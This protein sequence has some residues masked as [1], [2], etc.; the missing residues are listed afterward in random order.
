MAIVLDG[1]SGVSTPQLTA[2]GISTP[3]LTADGI[4]TPQL[5]AGNIV[6]QVCFFAML[7]PPTGFLK[8]N[9][10][11]VSRTT[12]ADLF[13]AIG[14][15]YGPGNGT[16]TFNLPDARGEFLR[17]WDDGRGVDAGRGFG[18]AQAQ[19]WK[20]FF[21]TNTVQNGTA[22]SHNNVDM[23]KSTTA[24]VG[25]LFAGSW[26]APAAGIGTKWNDADEVRSRNLAFLA[27]IKF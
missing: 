13:A 24:Y 27:C 25:N 5:S 11:A 4:S 20:G 1:T 8:C 15:L 18:T 9:G 12:Y 7:T 26:A 10:A 16:T 17:C 21:M 19:D 22:Y 3:Q 2:G 6:G 23:G 14:T